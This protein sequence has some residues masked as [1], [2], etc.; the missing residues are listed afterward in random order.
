MID[1]RHCR[2]IVLKECIK[3]WA[4]PHPVLAYR[5]SSAVFFALALG[6]G[7]WRLTRLPIDAFP[8]TT[9]VQVQI[10]TSAP[11][12]NPVEIEQ[13]V[14]LPIELTISGLPGLQQVRS[15]SKS[16]FSQVA[17]EFR[18]W[19]Q[20]GKRQDAARAQDLCDLAV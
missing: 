12:L 9:P 14:T 6:F 17:G 5:V 8:D 4:N 2:V 20:C 16:G 15:A 13:Q 18:L 7:A 3:P 19:A 10:N 1:A 11:A